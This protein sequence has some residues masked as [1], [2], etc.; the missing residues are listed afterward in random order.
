MSPL[1]SNIYLDRL[2]RYVE[3]TLLPLFNRGDRRRPYLP[4]TRI[5]KAAWKLGR[6]GER[7]AAR[8]LRQQVQA[9][10][11]RDPNDPDFRRLKYIRYADLCRVR[12]K[13]A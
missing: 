7:E 9:L 1:L 11:S 13:S 3:T 6:K 10:P 5:H 12:H 2:D 4:Y 8:Q